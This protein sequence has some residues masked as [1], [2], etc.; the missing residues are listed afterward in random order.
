MNEDTC[1]DIDT[2]TYIYKCVYISF[3]RPT[4][5]LLDGGQKDSQSY[6]IVI[7]IGNIMNDARSMTRFLMCLLLSKSR[8]LLDLC[9]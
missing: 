1:T 6:V 5:I 4:Y 8:V 2:F 9:P 7:I 3:F